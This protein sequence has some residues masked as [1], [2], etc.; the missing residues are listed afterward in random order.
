MKTMKCNDVKL[1][2]VSLA[3]GG[4]SE[5]EAR[6]AEAHVA[7]CA[8][9]RQ[10]LKLLKDDAVL[11]RHDPRPEVPAWLAGRIIAGVRERQARVR[12]CLAAAVPVGQFGLNRALMR[13]AA[14]VL[15]VAG[16]WL[17]T[18]LGRGIAGGQPSLGER[19]VEAGVEL[20][21]GEG[22]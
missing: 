19:L 13:I 22:R 5:R 4:L 20:P 16:I 3:D 1:L 10:E 6:A 14:V 15:V 18:A 2:L 12:P 7:T 8:R 17:G 11:L 21:A 9:C